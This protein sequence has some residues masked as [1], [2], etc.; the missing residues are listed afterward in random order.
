MIFDTLQRIG[1][2]CAYSHFRKAQEPPYIVYIGD[3]QDNFS[4]DNTFYHSRNSYQIE[5]YFKEKNEANEAK[6]EKALLSAGYQ[7]EKSEDNYI[8]DQGL[9][10]IYYNI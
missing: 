10:V 3:G 7:Y 4:A 2:P 5:Y 9:F 1:L 8:E 6:I